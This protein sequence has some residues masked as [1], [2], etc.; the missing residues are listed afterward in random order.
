MAIYILKTSVNTYRKSPQITNRSPKTFNGFQVSFKKPS[1]PLPLHS[2][3]TPFPRSTTAS[4]SMEVTN[5]PRGACFLCQRACS[6]FVVGVYDYQNS[7]VLLILLMSTSTAH[8]FP[9]EP[10]CDMHLL[11]CVS[12]SSRC[13]R[14][15][16]LRLRCYVL[17]RS[18][19]SKP[20]FRILPPSASFTSLSATPQPARLPVRCSS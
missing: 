17:P 12:P 16:R 14:R 11:V 9:T 5:S 1:K 8:T 6:S 20:S 10:M 7:T 13:T 18:S 2:F 4:S 3:H 15:D 19:T